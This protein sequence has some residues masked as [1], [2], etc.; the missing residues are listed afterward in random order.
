TFGGGTKLVVDS[1]VVRPTLTILP[2]SSEELQQGS[3]TL[4]CLASGGSPSTWSLSWKV[5]GR[6]PTTGTSNSLELLGS[7]GRFSWSS[8][9]KLS[10]DQWKEAGSVSCEASLSGQSPVTQSLQPQLCSV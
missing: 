5:G 2:P 10:A 4:A 1:G 6:S 7:D 8:T 3:A 9:L